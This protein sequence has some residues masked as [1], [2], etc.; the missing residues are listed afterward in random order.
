[1]KLVIK[2]CLTIFFITL[3]IST[4]AQI[5]GYSYKRELIGVNDTWHSI[6]I[7]IDLFSKIS[8]TLS[9]IRIIGITDK[10][11]TIETPYIIDFSAE[12]I[13]KKEIVFNQINESKNKQGYYFTFEIPTQKVINQIELELGQQNFDWRVL[14]EG[15][16]NQQ[17]WFSIIDNYRILSI[18]NEQTHFQFTKLIIPNSKYRFYRL[19]IKS[20]EKPYLSGAK[21]SLDERIDGNLINYKIETSKIETVKKET[22]IEIG[23]QSV[24]P[25]CFV[26]IKIKDGFDYYRPVRIEYLADSINTDKGWKYS[27]Y[28]VES[29]TVNSFEKNEFRFSS[30]FAKRFRIIIDNQDNKPLSIDSVLVKGYKYELKARF[31][32]SAKYFIIYGNKNAFAPS[33][34]I[35]LFTDKIPATLSALNLGDEQYIGKEERQKS[36]PLFQN[37]MWLW[38]IMLVIIVLLGW[39][40]IRMI[41]HK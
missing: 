7:P 24:V 23:L 41:K 22:I 20:N 38:G 29:G 15:S 17:Q 8:P 16:N 25:V 2:H 3:C 35:A 10:N 6:T 30:T 32:E 19:C 31:T 18:D 4:Q 14:L 13:S 36:H 9:D 1:M 34:D 28:S 12:K 27:Y 5:K 11:D 39:F 37:K 40:S 26:D 21:I 33:Y